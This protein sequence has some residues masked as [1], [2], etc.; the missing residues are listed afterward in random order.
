MNKNIRLKPTEIKVICETFCHHFDPEDH[1]WLF[2]SR[3]NPEALGGDIDL[4]IET[5]IQN[6]EDVYQR[7]L[8]F[9]IELYKRIGEQKIDVIVNLLS[10]SFHS[11]I[12]DIAKQE[13]IKL[14]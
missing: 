6:P 3:A 7:K 13:G 2:G 5:V 14:V 9:V 12:H 10:S 11:P 4:Y 8:R 1:L